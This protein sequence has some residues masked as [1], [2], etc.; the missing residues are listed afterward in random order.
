MKRSIPYDG[1]HYAG[2]RPGQLREWIEDLRHR[3]FRGGHIQRHRALLTSAAERR[4]RALQACALCAILLVPWLFL[5]KWVSAMWGAILSFWTEVL[6]ITGYVTMVRYRIADLYDFAAPY[7]HVHSEAP[8]MFQLLM[9][10]LITLVLFVITFLLPRRFLPLAYLLRVVVLFQ[11]CAQ[12]FFTFVPVDFPYSASGYIHGVLIAGLAMVTVV[13]V[14]LAFTHFV[15]DFTWWRRMG[16]ALMIMVYFIVSLPMQYMAHAAVLHLT[17]LLYLPILFFVFG[18]PL[19]VVAFI[20]F[21]SWG[22]SWRSSLY[23]EYPPRG[24]GFF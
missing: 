2:A 18:L 16:L 6:G 17:S 12:T 15:F 4:H 10:W 11:A 19:N 7:V 24:N 13:P 22:A 23:E 8:D 20:S 21:Y 1:Y 14:V 9:G 3:G 5:M